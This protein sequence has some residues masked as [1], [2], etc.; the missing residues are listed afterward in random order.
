MERKGKSPFLAELGASGYLVFRHEDRISEGMATT[1]SLTQQSTDNLL[2]YTMQ[3]RHLET[4]LIGDL[5]K[6]YYK[7]YNEKIKPG[8]EKIPISYT[9]SSLANKMRFFNAYNDWEQLLVLWAKKNGYL[10]R[11]KLISGG[12]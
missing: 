5:D 2:R 8:I 6:E 3:V 12:E 7:I 11:K 4:L 1:L 9:W 10:G